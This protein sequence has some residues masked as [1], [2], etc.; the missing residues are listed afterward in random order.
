MT[1]P[2]NAKY[3]PT[4]LMSNFAS[5]FAK[6]PRELRSLSLQKRRR[7]CSRLLAKAAKWKIAN[8]ESSFS[9]ISET[10]IVKEKGVQVYSLTRRLSRPT[11]SWQR[12]NIFLFSSDSN[13]SQ[14]KFA[15]QFRFGAHDYLTSDQSSLQNRF[16]A[17]SSVHNLLISTSV[18]FPG[19][20]NFSAANSFGIQRIHTN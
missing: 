4:W 18:G 11:Q 1:V 3:F 15:Q 19:V 13:F 5:E 10:V 8:I 14:T 12:W 7:R 6:R 9:D 16:G 20:H 17:N 2:S